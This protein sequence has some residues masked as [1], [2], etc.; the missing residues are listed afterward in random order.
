MLFTPFGV[1]QNGTFDNKM[2]KSTSKGEKGSIFL[3]VKT[4]LMSI[5]SVNFIELSREH[6]E[7]A[8]LK[9]NSFIVLDLQKLKKPP[10][11]YVAPSL[12][13]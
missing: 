3:Q 7:V 1:T 4:L 11:F 2:H 12:K 9:L 10:N 8:I 6:L 5:L 13:D